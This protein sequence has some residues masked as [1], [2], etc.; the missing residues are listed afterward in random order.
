MKM[1]VLLINRAS[2]ASGENTILRYG[3]SIPLLRGFHPL[4]KERAKDGARA[5]VVC[6]DGL[7]KFGVRIPPVET[8][9]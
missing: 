5:F 9:A 8:R 4:R 6:L 3:K 2:G 7:L 1:N